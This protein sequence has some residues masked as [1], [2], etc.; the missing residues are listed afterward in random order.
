MS[1]LSAPGWWQASDGKWY[2]PALLPAGWGINGDGTVSKLVEPVSAETAVDDTVEPGQVREGVQSPSPAAAT[3]ASVAH[4][5]SCG[6]P[7][8]EGARFCP[9]C[10]RALADSQLPERG[11]DIATVTESGHVRVRVGR[12]LLIALGVAAVIGLAGTAFALLRS[13]ATSKHDISGSFTLF[14]TDLLGDEGEPCEGDGGYSDLGS[15]TPVR[16]TD[17]EGKL[18]GATTLGF[19]DIVS[20]GT[21][22]FDFLLEDVADTEF[23]RFEV[24]DRGEISYPKEDL[25]DIGWSVFFSIGE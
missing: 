24:G 3:I 16:V 25:E 19:G 7:L 2:P 9:R 8:P 14:D 10:G 15:G 12:V 21:C 20:S 13:K 4:C 18:I 1:D 6:M 22:S 23:Y 11:V 5:T 17:A